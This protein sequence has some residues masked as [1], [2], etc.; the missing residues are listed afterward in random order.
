M[1]NGR[2]TCLSLFVFALAVF[3]C[4]DCRNQTKIFL[5]FGPKVVA[6]VL[7]TISLA[8]HGQSTDRSVQQLANLLDNMLWE[9]MGLSAHIY[10]SN[11]A[12]K[13]GPIW[14]TKT[15]AR[16]QASRTTLCKFI[17]QFECLLA[18]AGWKVHYFHVSACWTMRVHRQG[19]TLLSAKQLQI[20][21]KTLQK[22]AKPQEICE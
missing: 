3:S 9:E 7:N 17:A 8:V 15:R 1:L 10:H 2:K 5:S 4:S 22:S 18:Q 21:N 12:E 11:V 20:I 19:Y 6:W 14:G 13:D 16:C